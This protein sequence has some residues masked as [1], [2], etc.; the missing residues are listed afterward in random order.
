VGVAAKAL[1]PIIAIAKV[2][3]ATNTANSV[4]IFL[5]ISVFHYHRKMGKI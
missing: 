3:T 4:D 1:K 2:M 5:D